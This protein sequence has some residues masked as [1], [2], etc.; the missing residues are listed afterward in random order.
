MRNPI[1]AAGWLM[2]YVVLA[3][4]PLALSLIDM[5]PG[6]GFWVNV[7]VGLGF[8]GL[9]LMGLQ[10]VLAARFVLATE[11]FGYDVVL[12]AHRQMTVLITACLLAH[13]I[14]LFAWDTRY[15]RLLNVVEA[16][17]R[18]RFAVASVVLLLLLIATSLRREAFRLGY[19]TWQVLHAALAI[20]IVV[21]GLTHVLLIGYYV[22]EP[23]EQAVWAVYSAAFIAIGIWVRLLRPLVRWRRRW[24]IV[25]VREQPGHGHTI[26]LTPVN[27]HVYGERGFD[28][29][30][31]QF[32]WIH[33]GR[34]PFAMAYHPFSISSSAEQHDAVEFTIKTERGFTAHI[35][36]LKVGGVVYLDGPWGQFTMQRHEGPGFVFLGGGIG[37]T[38]LLSML[39]TMADRADPRPCWIFVGNRREDQIVGF[40]ELESLVARM[41]LTV[42]HSLSDPGPSWTGRRGRVDVALLDQ[43]LPPNRARLQYFMCGSPPMMDAAEAALRQ[44]RIPDQQVHSERF[45]MA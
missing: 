2:L 40:N 3:T 36:D 1:T 19:R 42:V 33:A 11:A 29:E 44:L 4:A 24:R 34:S 10:F 32:A 21:T 6:R 35:H 12:Q 39:A 27:P 9:A 38:P 30:P 43:V 20:L 25:E 8:I 23:W 26:R 13:P 22:D 17:P 15:L 31:G 14:V 45:S 16:P 7:S 5:D 41:N 18:A 28:F 37:I